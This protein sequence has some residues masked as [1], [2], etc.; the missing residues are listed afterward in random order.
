M[1]GGATVVT[2]SV[3]ASNGVAH[4]IDGVLMPPAEMP[5]TAGSY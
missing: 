2:P 5:D 3:A 4:M 1:V